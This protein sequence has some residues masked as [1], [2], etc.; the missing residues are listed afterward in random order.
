MVTPGKKTDQLFLTWLVRQETEEYL[1]QLLVPDNSLMQDVPTMFPL[2]P[3]APAKATVPETQDVPEQKITVSDPQAEEFLTWLT[4]KSIAKSYKKKLRRKEKENKRMSEEIHQELG[5][6]KLSLNKSKGATP[7][8]S[9]LSSS[10]SLSPSLSPSHSPSPSSPLSTSASERRALSPHSSLASL[11]APLPVPPKPLFVKK[12]YEKWPKYT[13][14]FATS[15]I[16]EFCGVPPFL[17][18]LFH[19]KLGGH[20]KIGRKPFLKYLF[21][22]FVNPIHFLHPLLP[23]L[24][25][26]FYFLPLLFFFF[27]SFESKNA[28]LSSRFYKSYIHNQPPPTKLFHIISS[29]SSPQ[30]IGPDDLVILLEE[31]LETHPTLRWLLDEQEARATYSKL[32][33]RRGRKKK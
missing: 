17:T 6:K 10:P 21:S 32:R 2:V 20:L 25:I 1:Q 12:I 7:P 19:R 29:P 28:Y 23:F 31:L 24:I 18:C 15:S 3:F 11:P 26:L 30:V 9:P 33:R 5:E 13:I 4:R 8:T 16:L 27:E 14:P 22:I